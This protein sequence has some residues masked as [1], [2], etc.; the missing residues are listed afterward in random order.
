M[1]IAIQNKPDVEMK[2]DTSQN[3][4]HLNAGQ[5]KL[6]KGGTQRYNSSR[7]QQ[8]QKSSLGLKEKDGFVL[9]PDESQTNRSNDQVIAANPSS[10]SSSGIS[11]WVSSMK[12][13]FQRF[14]ANLE[15][16]KLLSSGQTQEANM[17]SHVSSSESLDEIFFK[18]KQRPSR[19]LDDD[20]DVENDDN[21][22]SKSNK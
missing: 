9:D 6:P 15:A 2:P 11:T 10:S 7:E 14:K 8:I 5:S 16:K 18:L 20:I 12:T 1:S 22:S 13:G 21:P 19:S 3:K 17:T 4:D